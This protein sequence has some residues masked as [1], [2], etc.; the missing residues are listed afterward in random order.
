MIEKTSA[1]TA[2]I[3]GTGLNEFAKGEGVDS[4]DTPFGAMSA[5]II[6]TNHEGCQL[7]F[8]PRHGQPHSIP[9]HKVNYRANLWGLKRLGIKNVIAVNA[10]GGINSNMPAGAIVIPDQVVDYTY[11]REHSYFDGVDCNDYQCIDSEKVAFEKLIGTAFN[12]VTQHIDFTQPFSKRLCN[13][14]SAA[15]D[16]L[17][18]AIV[19]GATY[20]ATQ[21]PRLETAAEIRRLEQDG[22][23]IVGM[24]A[25]PEAALARELGIEYASICLVVN[26]AAGK[27]DLAITMEDIHRVIDGGMSTVRQLLQLAITKL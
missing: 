20:A 19:D 26:P 27:S 16:E 3:G 23:D 18:I 22:C 14:L 11:G 5:P 9:P 12:P 24:T 25:M 1:T 6:C 8:I 15:A 7:A 2:I 4:V 21:G 10:V 13:V 17:N